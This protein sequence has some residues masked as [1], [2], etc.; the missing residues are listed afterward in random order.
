MSTGKSATPP[1]AAST[2]NVLPA[3]IALSANE[4]KLHELIEA[5]IAAYKKAKGEN[6]SQYRSGA[7]RAFSL[8]LGHWHRTSTEVDWK[9]SADG[10]TASAARRKSTAPPK[11]MATAAK[12][13]PS[14]KP[15]IAEKTMTAG[16]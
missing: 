10:A 2:A 3:A 7:L 13:A 16:S 1:A 6:L 15:V 12:A 5:D 4:R 8:A 14:A 11:P 9:V